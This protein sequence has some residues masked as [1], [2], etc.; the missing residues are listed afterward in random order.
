MKTLA[1]EADKAMARGIK[2]ELVSQYPELATLNA[3][4]SA[5]INLDEGLE[6][7]VNRI[8]NYDIIKLGDT[9]IGAGG[10]ASGGPVGALSAGLLKH[11]LEAPTMKAR[12]AFTLNKA[13]RINPGEVTRKGAAYTA[14]Q[15]ID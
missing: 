4:D 14:G 5:L 12:L 6:R 2:E 11:V 8:R 1:I 13:K 7:A 10:L 15:T 3:K 9:V